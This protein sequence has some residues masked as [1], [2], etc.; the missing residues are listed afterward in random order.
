[1]YSHVA[2]LWAV[3]AVTGGLAARLPSGPGD[4]YSTTLTYLSKKH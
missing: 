4:I 2:S 3:L 1:M